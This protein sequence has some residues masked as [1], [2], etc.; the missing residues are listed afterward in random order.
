MSQSHVST[1]CVR[2][3]IT[4]VAILA[5]ASSITVQAQVPS[6]AYSYSRESSF[7]YYDSAAGV[8]AGLLKIERVEPN[9]PNLCVETEYSYDDHGN[10]TGSTTRN[11]TNPGGSP[12]TGR[13]VFTARSSSSSYAS[14]NVTLKVRGANGVLGDVAVSVPTGA[15]ASSSTNAVGHGEE[16]KIDP[17]YGALVSLTGPNALTTGYELDDWGRVVRENRADGTSTRS[18]Y[19]LI[20]GRVTDTSSNSSDC[21]PTAAL[22]GLASEIPSRSDGWR[23]V[24]YVQVQSFNSDGVAMGPAQRVYK[25]AEGRTIRELSQGF[26]GGTQA[27]D[28]RYIVK[29]TVYNAYGVAVVSTG[30]Y[31]LESGSPSTSG[32][33]DMALSTSVIDALGRPIEIYQRDLKGSVASI[34]YGSYGTHKSTRTLIQYGASI[35]TTLLASSSPL[36]TA[37]TNDLGQTRLEEK[38]ANG[39]LVRVTDAH[40]AQLVHQHDAFGNLVATKDPLQNTISLSYDIR[41]RKLSMADPDTGTWNYDYNAL[42][43]LVWQQSPNQLAQSQDTTMDYDLLGRLIKRTEPGLK[44]T[45][46]YDNCTKGKG[47]LCSSG[48]DNNVSKTYTYDGFGRPIATQ[49]KSAISDGPS[50]NS[51]VSYEAKTGRLETQTYPTGVKVQYVYTTMGF[52]NKVQLPQAV[53]ITPDTNPGQAAGATVNWA[54]NKAIWSSGKVNARGQSETSDLGNGVTSRAS[55]EGP[56]GRLDNL[57]VGAGS[58]TGVAY[59]SYVWDS[60]GNLK[61][62]VDQNGDGLTGAVTDSYVYDSLNRLAQYTV[63]AVAAGNLTR[64]VDLQYNAIGNLLHKSDVGNYI[65]SSGASGC[66][67]RQPHAVGKV[68]LANE[69]REYCYDANGNAISATAGAWRSISYTSFNLP[70]DEGGVQGA[71]G[72]KYTW[73]YDENHQ[74]LKEI[75]VNAQGTRTTWSLHPDNQGGLGF[76]TE[77]TGTSTNLNRHYISAGG[78]SLVIVTREALTVY[79]SSSQASPPSVT[80]VN[81]V[82]VEFWHKDHLGSLIAT[83]NH[84]GSVTQRYAYDPFGKRRQASGQYDPFGAL[85]I[86]WVDGSSKSTDRGYTGHEHLDDVGIVHMNGRLFDPLTGRFLQP[87]PFI[88]L[89]DDLQNYNRYSYC[90]NGPLICTD[91]TGLFNLKKALKIVVAIVATVYLGPAGAA[92]AKGGIFAAGGAFAS[93]GAVV[94]GNFMAQAAVAGFVSGAISTG[95]IK[96]ALQGAF[97]GAVFAGVGNVVRGGEFFSGAGA[98]VNQTAHY[99]TGVALHGVAG[100]VTSVAGGGKCGPGA[101]SAAFTKSLSSSGLMDGIN[102]AAEGG[103]WVARSQGAVISA[104]AGGTASVLGG[105]KFENGAVTGAFSYLMNQVSRLR[106]TAPGIKA[107]G[108]EAQRVSCIDA[109]VGCGGLESRGLGEFDVEKFRIHL[110]KEFF[111]LLPIGNGEVYAL[112]AAVDGLYIDK[113]TGGHIALKAGDTWKYGQTL[114]GGRYSGAELT[115]GLAGGPLNYNPIAQGNQLQIRMWESIFLGGYQIRHFRLP[116]GNLKEWD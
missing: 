19:C 53:S 58:T 1:S 87:D 17:R 44:S 21:G 59:H 46:T 11:C 72:L 116:P 86:D 24:S 38:N 29:D 70:N 28:R 56:T 77:S 55:F 110:L 62:R 76:E 111:T 80:A 50:F 114:A 4:L 40:K 69:T 78:Q 100:C 42:G 103:D 91:P 107:P 35:P 60:I 52:L 93:V 57:Q 23:A 106:P 51:A 31:F 39:L 36:A 96:G 99:L 33:N 113:A 104:V 41:G 73:L 13:A 14:F 102:A 79:A 83:T 101:L 89:M 94:G 15:F 64:T 47:K 75:R 16:R 6:D 8:K 98:A 81:A 92:W 112:T 109:G 9:N 20:S 26:D 84:A 2:A 68:V 25:D 45:W 66:T 49:V 10:R 22:S 37:T 32:S 67:R 61:T 27:T 18:I 82:K 65:Y 105:G 34:A 5:L 115:S 108:P 7:Q 95:S 48:A 85:V 3:P 30:T 63:Q 90:Y 88:Q 74:R 71:N 54:A 97:T 12:A 43:E